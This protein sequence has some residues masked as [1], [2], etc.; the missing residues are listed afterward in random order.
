MLQLTMVKTRSVTRREERAKAPSKRP[1]H[2]YLNGVRLRTCLC[3]SS[4]CRDIARCW[5]RLNDKKR[6]RYKRVPSHEIF[7][8]DKACL[9]N[10]VVDLAC[11][12][13]IGHGKNAP[14]KKGASP[15]YVAYHHYHPILLKEN[16]GGPVD[17][18]DS[19]LARNIANMT[20]HDQQ[21]CGETKMHH[22]VQII[23]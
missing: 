13:L 6:C 10:Q 22:A 4:S 23:C 18:A 9:S 15:T 20:D 11:H 17:S 12:H 2:N 14:R 21:D 1:Y 7:K 16:N 8:M 3:G 19:D 5:T